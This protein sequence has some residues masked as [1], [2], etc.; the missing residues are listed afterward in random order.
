MFNNFNTFYTQ[1]NQI[2]QKQMEKWANCD[3]FAKHADKTVRYYKV[4]STVIVDR[5]RY[6]VPDSFDILR[7]YICDE[8]SFKLISYF[9]G[10]GKCNYNKRGR[11][12]KLDKHAVNNR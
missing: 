9:F 7:L 2:R 3:C 4:Q 11:K 6:I 8:D 10:N 5:N 12:T 1:F